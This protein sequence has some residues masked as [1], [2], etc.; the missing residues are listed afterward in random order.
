[1][2]IA[3][4]ID[5]TLADF[6]SAFVRYYNKTKGSDFSVDDFTRPD[7][8]NIMDISKEE[9]LETVYDFYAS[10]Y[11]TE[12]EPIAN[13]IITVKKLAEKHSLICVSARAKNIKEETRRWIVK[14]Y[15]DAIKNIFLTDL[16]LFNNGRKNKFDFCHEAGATLLID[17]SPKF[18]EECTKNGIKT[19]LFD[20]PWNRNIE[21]GD[22]L[23]RVK[24]WSDISDILM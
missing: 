3:I 1:M 17:D 9:I 19:L 24:S 5:D 13:S 15:G 23:E 18:T 2:I 12:V 11:F 4:D 16:H 21:N 10:P 22:Y 20:Q 14:H 6:S 7:W 8:W